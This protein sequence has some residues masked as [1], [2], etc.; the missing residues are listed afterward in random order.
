MPGSAAI[1][2][3]RI[4]FSALIIKGIYG[5]E[6]YETCYKMTSMIQSGL[7]ISPV[8]TQRFPYTEFKE[9]IE[10]MKSGNLRR[11][12]ARLGRISTGRLRRSEN[13]SRQDRSSRA[14]FENRG[15][16]SQSLLAARLR[17]G[18]G[19]PILSCI[20]CGLPSPRA[21]SLRVKLRRVE[22]LRRDLPS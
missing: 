2:W 20:A 8:I 12:R 4:V 7:D 22:S 11:N 21:T 5:R 3:N 18:S 13:R 16:I 19:S 14:R 10:L 17:R 6:M 15:F 9:T 1:D